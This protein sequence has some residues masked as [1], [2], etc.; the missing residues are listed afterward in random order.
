[1][2]INLV[3]SPSPISWVVILPLPGFPFAQ[4]ELIEAQLQNWVCCF[5]PCLGGSAR[6]LCGLEILHSLHPQPVEILPSQLC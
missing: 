5:L 2:L 6:C 3:P 4:P 1:M